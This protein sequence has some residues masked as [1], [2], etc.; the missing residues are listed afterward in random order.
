MLPGGSWLI[1]M[2]Q[3]CFLGC[4]TGIQY[5]SDVSLRHDFAPHTS[6]NIDT[7]RYIPVCLLLFFHGYSS[8]GSGSANCTKP[9]PVRDTVVFFFFCE[10]IAAE[11]A[12]QQIVPYSY[13]YQMLASILLKAS[14]ASTRDTIYCG[15][16]DGACYYC[17][18][19]YHMYLVN[20][21]PFSTER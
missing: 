18:N 16:N 7:R 10:S 15:P 13:P 21:V 17:G 1:W 14:R 4:T 2:I 11:A 6:Y 3:A 19:W 5:D 20:V 9:E 8:R 12:E